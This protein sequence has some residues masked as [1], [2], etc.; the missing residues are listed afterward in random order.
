[1]KKIITFVFV[2]VV[3][4]INAQI[5]HGGI[6][7]AKKYNNLSKNI[8]T[9]S[10]E[11]QDARPYI[12]EDAITDKYKD[13]VWRFGININVN[14]DFKNQALQERVA[15]GT[16][17]RLRIYSEGATS[18]NF[19]FD[20][21]RIP[22][23]SQLFVYNNSMSEILGSFTHQNNKK[24]GSLGV[25]LIF[26]DAVIIEYYEPDNVDF[27]GELHINRVTH[28]YRNAMIYADKGLGSSGSCNNDVVCP[29]ADPWQTEI[30][31]TAMLVTN[32]NGFC[33]GA[34][35]NNTANDETP[36]FLTANHCYSNDVNDWVFW[37]NWNMESCGG[38][39]ATS[40]DDISGCTV[41]ARNSDSDFLL[42]ELSSTPPESYHVFYAGW[43]KRDI[44]DNSSVCIHHPS[45]D[46]TKISW[47][48]DPASSS[49]YDPSPYL[50]DSH[51]KITAWDD[52]TTEGGSSGSPLFNQD[53]RIVGQLHGG[54]ASCSSN[55]AD[56]YGKFSMSW[57]RGTS[58]ETRL[59]DWLDPQGTNPDY[60]DGFDPGALADDIQ[61][62][63][64]PEPIVRY[65]N[66]DTIT[67]TVIIKNAGNNAITSCVVSYF[68]DDGQVVQQNWTG[69][70]D[71]YGASDTITFPE[72]T[73]T[74]GQ[75]LIKAFVSN[76]NGNNDSNTANDS[77]QKAFEVVSIT[78]EE[79]PFSEGFENSPLSVTFENPD[80]STTW[81][82]NT[83]AAGNG[84]NTCYYINCHDYNNTGAEDFIVL[85]WLNINDYNAKLT[86][87]VAYRRYSSS[88]YEKLKVVISDDCESTWSTVYF[89]QS[90]ELATGPDETDVFTPSLASDWRTDTVDLSEYVNKSVKIK[91]VSVNGYGNNI[92][93]DDI[94]IDSPTTSGKNIET[95]DFVKIYPN[96]AKDYIII[97]KNNI[98]ATSIIDITGKTVVEINDNNKNLQLKIN[99]NKLDKGVYFVK[100]R[101][102][103]SVKFIKY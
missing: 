14:I 83:N 3:F 33:S 57:D 92:Y 4:T 100:F 24:Y 22:K 43:D 7:F 35:V 39:T 16:L 79:L 6:P 66:E 37:F 97:N 73:L 12:Q 77:L 18:I 72:I 87:K 64:I 19:R 55:T 99:I 86:F 15:N 102:Y 5:S 78:A 103:K 88:W 29:E 67:P 8:P 2:L 36:Y 68:I 17:Y 9:I 52:G 53:H 11:K 25:S 58:P 20:K 61:L 50:A 71:T 69:N 84:S 45:G 42:L 60:I 89:K 34:L 46:V 62:L 44:A 76:P 74:Y 70:L 38:N 93:I 98:T 80:N 81:E 75:H 40:H 10:M 30:R 41:K 28:G 65:C 56:Y 90:T 63:S 1:M 51:W 13:H 32:G 91:I 94:K 85:P 23:G 59:K 49:D 31:S 101:N 26:D 27:S 48:N 96:P 95:E 54:Y 47:D 82:E 21:F